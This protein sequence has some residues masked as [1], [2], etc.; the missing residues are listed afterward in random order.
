MLPEA[1]IMPL[2]EM[3][4]ELLIPLEL[5]SKKSP[6]GNS[7]T[8]FPLVVLTINGK[9]LCILYSYYIFMR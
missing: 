5:R 4:P 6:D 3:L 7:W 1:L 8:L 2:T 9:R